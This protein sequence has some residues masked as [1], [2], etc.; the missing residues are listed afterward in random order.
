MIVELKNIFSEKAVPFS[1]AEDRLDDL[2]FD[3]GIQ[4]DGEIVKED[5]KYFVKGRYKGILIISC[6]RCLTLNK[7]EISGEFSG[8]YLDK[9]N[10]EKYISELKPEEAIE[11]EFFELAENNEIDLSSLVREHIILDLPEYEYCKPK[12]EQDDYLEKYTSVEVDSRWQQLL[13]IEK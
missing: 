4:I 11:N 7:V 2:E 12:C 6:V 1:Y 9:K 5:N 13:D 10:Y 3:N 8:I